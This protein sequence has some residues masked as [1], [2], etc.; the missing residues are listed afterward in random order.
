M[1]LGQF[2]PMAATDHHINLKQG[3]CPEHQI[4]YRKGPDIGEVSTEHI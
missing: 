2:E 3:T 4:P 1:C